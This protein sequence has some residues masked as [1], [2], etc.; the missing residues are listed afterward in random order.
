MRLAVF[1]FTA[2]AVAGWARAQEP[3]PAQEDP[4]APQASDAPDESVAEPALETELPVTLDY[5]QG[6]DWPTTVAEFE[7]LAGEHPERLSLSSLGTSRGGNELWIVT[8]GATQ[9]GHP[10][11][12]PALFLC[13]DLE[14][15]TDGRRSGPGAGLFVARTLLERARS[16]ETIA[17]LFER[18]T[19]YIAFAPDPDGLLGA[20]DGRGLNRNFPVDWAPF[21]EAASADASRDQGP[22]PL[23]EPESLALA[24]FLIEH[25][26]VT[27]TVLWTRRAGT[28]QGTCTASEKAA[29]T[30]LGFD[31]ELRRELCRLMLLCR[32]PGSLGLFCHLRL[33]N[34]VI[35]YEAH[36]GQAADGPLGPAPSGYPGFC[37]L[38]LSLLE[39]LPRLEIG[40]ARIERLRTDL[41]QVDLPV[42]IQVALASP[43]LDLAIRRRGPGAELEVVGAELELVALESERARG[44]KALEEALHEVP[45]GVLESGQATTVRLIVRAEAGTELTLSARALGSGSDN[46]TL[47]LE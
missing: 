21:V 22:Y 7:R 45:L 6:P 20:Q 33:G 8:L 25:P 16:D 38:A 23:S 44:F 36:R 17:R 43:P 32:A 34:H 24:R 14:S 41:W 18:A 28:S 47:T 40:E 39:E 4:P 1:L 29:L 13:A 46:K 27:A 11:E 10:S 37:R 15:G 35:A 31:Y 12:R 9:V 5:T 2:L 30:E 3:E 42:G 19:L 26:S